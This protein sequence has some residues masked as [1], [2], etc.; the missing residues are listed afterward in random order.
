MDFNE[1]RRYE[2]LSPFELKNK[3][4][5]LAT[6]HSERTLLN[7]ARGNPNWIALE[8]RQ[9]FMQLGMFALEE[10]AKS[11]LAP[12][13]GAAR[14]PAGLLRDFGAFAA[15]H[16]GAPGIEFL[17]RCLACAGRDL[18]IGGEELLQELAGAVLGDHYP[19]PPRMPHFR[20]AA[21]G[22]LRARA[23]QPYRL[24]FRIA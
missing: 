11:P 2:K 18:G 22:L 23:R 24:L 8:P 9:A 16:A 6:D 1:E 20:D 15:R 5:E 4:I 12:G 7:A 21:R 13:F 14:L 3:L 10:S 19:T 17:K